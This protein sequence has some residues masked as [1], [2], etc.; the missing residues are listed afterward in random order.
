MLPL[1]A[2]AEETIAYAPL[3]ALKPAIQS[4]AALF[5]S[6]CNP[7]QLN[8]TR[9]LALPCH[10]W[11]CS[12]HDASDALLHQQKESADQGT[13][14]ANTRGGCHRHRPLL[15]SNACGDDFIC[16]QPTLGRCHRASR[17]RR[18]AP[19]DAM[20]CDP[21]RPRPPANQSPPARARSP[22]PTATFARR[23][24]RPQRKE[25]VAAASVGRPRQRRRRRQL[26]AASCRRRM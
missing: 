7:S 5:A 26:L 25:G 20:R 16:E 13:V 22:P 23:C 19:S 18:R 6:L 15:Q 1:H 21:I 4:L 14:F 10:W 9:P 11:R 8:G 12:A 24:R 3:T 2:S 17:R